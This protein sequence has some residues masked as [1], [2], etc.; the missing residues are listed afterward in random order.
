MKDH[1]TNEAILL[2]NNDEYLYNL[3]SDV[4]TVTE[5]GEVFN[6]HVAPRIRDGIQLDVYSLRDINFSE[7]LDR[8][9]TKI[10]A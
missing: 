9:K 7:L 1:A 3:F 10:G 5:L 4:S 6:V 2:I 8:I